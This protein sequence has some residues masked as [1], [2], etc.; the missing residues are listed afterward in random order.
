MTYTDLIRQR[1]ITWIT[2]T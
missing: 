1:E 2:L